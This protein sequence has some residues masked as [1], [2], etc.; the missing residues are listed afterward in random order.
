[1][2]DFIFKKTLFEKL[3]KTIIYNFITFTHIVERVVGNVKALEVAEVARTVLRL[4]LLRLERKFHQPY[5][6]VVD[7]KFF[8][9]DEKIKIIKKF[10]ILK[11]FQPDKKT[12]LFKYGVNNWKLRA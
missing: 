8:Q 4:L 10:S 11:F 1:M 3:H 9:P 2:R 7:I 6:A 5:L 12:N